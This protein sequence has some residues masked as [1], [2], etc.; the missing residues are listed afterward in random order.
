VPAAAHPRRSPSALSFGYD[1][2]MAESPPFA[3]IAS[4]FKAPY[5][6]DPSRDDA[7]VAVLGIP[8][9]EA[10]TARP[11]ARYGPRAMRDASTNWAYRDGA[12]PFYDGEVGTEL[13]G[14]VRFV[15]TG[16]VDLPPTVP[17]E[18]S[19]PLIAGRVGRLLAQGLFPVVLGG[20]HSITFPILKAFGERRLHLVQ[21]DTHMDYWHDEGGMLYTHASPIVRSHEAGVAARVTQIGIRGLHTASDQIELARER[22]VTT[23][24]CEQA[25]RTPVDELLAHIQPGEEVYITFDI[26]CLD[27]SIAPGTGTPEPGGFSYYEAKAMLR[28]LALKTTVVGMDM[29]EVNPLYDPMEITALHAVRLI[30][31]TVGAALTPR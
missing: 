31:D 21:F 19:H 12:E 9:D 11:G 26:D 15:D 14:G 6:A 24:W 25:K 13:L 18:R 23:F 17:P 29:V 20:D 22:G 2:R 7:D 30:F 8:Y 5:I 1:S 4:F 16:D 27:P 28:A 10:T 3:G